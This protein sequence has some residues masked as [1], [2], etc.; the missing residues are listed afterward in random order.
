MK[1][2][3]LNQHRSTRNRYWTMYMALGLVV[4]LFVVLRFFPIIKLFYMSL[5]NWNMASGVNKFLGFRN[6][7]R[8]FSNSTFISALWRTIYIGFEILLITV[9]LALLLSNAIHRKIWAKGFAQTG[10]FIPYIMPMVPTVIIWKWLFN[11]EYGLVN[12]MLSFL[13]V[14]KL[15]WLSNG[16]L[17]E[18]AIVII[19]VWK[20]LGYCVL[21]LTVGLA[22]ISRTYY[23]AAEIDGASSRNT[24]FHITLPLLKPV[25]IY[26]SIIM[27]I[28][29]FNVYTQA[30]ILCSDASGSPG[31]VV[32]T[33]VYDMVENGFKFNKMGY[34][35]AE[36]VVL[37]LII[38]LLS[39]IQFVFG[40]E[41]RMDRWRMKRHL[42]R[43]QPIRK[44][45]GC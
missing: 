6:F 40:D 42:R 29:G 9:P 18:W 15:G 37:F 17:A 41:E 16:T 5:F 1:G 13:G 11:T 7:V 23:E 30:Y 21:I 36:A 8:M 31:Y 32:R 44:G 38:F 25:L 2:A 34:A 26:V 10:L 4:L 27:L 43:E 22:G 3:G 45:C 35:A 33:L 24:F 14:S 20:N 28:R 12:Y 39:M 19:T